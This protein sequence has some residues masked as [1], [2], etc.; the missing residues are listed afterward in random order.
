MVRD[1]RKF[2]DGRGWLSE[3]FRHDEL[4]AEF[5]PAMAYTSSTKAGVTRGRTSMSIRPIFLLFP[6][7]VKFQRYACGTIARTHLPIEM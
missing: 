2:N 5:F 1:L 6:G 3:L 4:T 7:A